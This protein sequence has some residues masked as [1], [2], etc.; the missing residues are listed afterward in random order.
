M[1]IPRTKRL[2]TF[3]LSIFYNNKDYFWVCLTKQKEK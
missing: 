3:S 1:E 2:V